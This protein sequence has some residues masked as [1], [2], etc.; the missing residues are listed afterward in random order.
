MQKDV[1]KGFPEW[2]ERVEVPKKDGIV[3]HPARQRRAVAALDGQPEHITP[4]VWTVARAATSYHPDLCV[5][6]LDPSRR[7]AR[8]PAR[9]GARPCA[10]CSTSS[11]CRAG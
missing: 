3:H 7:R 9:R 1:S 10:T 5:F 4:H 8:G 2:L 6:D 11:A